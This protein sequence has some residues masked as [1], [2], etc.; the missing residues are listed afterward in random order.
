M[1]Y[2]YHTGNICKKHTL[3]RKQ[4][5]IECYIE[6]LYSNQIIGRRCVR[7]QT[8]KPNKSLVSDFDVL[9]IKQLKS[10]NICVKFMC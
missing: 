1:Y 5:F 9:I 8:L 2:R 7:L 4:L 6:F 10:R 3:A